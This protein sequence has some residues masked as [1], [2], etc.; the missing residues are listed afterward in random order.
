MD[1]RN[2][3]G[4]VMALFYIFNSISCAAEKCNNAEERE[5][6]NRNDEKNTNI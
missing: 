4:F 6:N 2:S 5:N 1:V 3:I